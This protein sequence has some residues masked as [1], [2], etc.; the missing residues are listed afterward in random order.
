MT[1]LLD[2]A[3]A[4]LMRLPPTRQDA[5]AVHVL[6]LIAVVGAHAEP[7]KQSGEVFGRSKDKLRY[8]APG[9]TLDDLLTAEDVDLWQASTIDG[10]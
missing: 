1:Q 3:I 9:D 4:E 10:R 5:V 8:M 2:K 6:E 7:P